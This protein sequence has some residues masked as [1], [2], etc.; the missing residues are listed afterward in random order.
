MADARENAD[1]I[2]EGICPSCGSI[3]ETVYDGSSGSEM[4]CPARGCRV[5]LKIDVYGDFTWASGTPE[6]WTGEDA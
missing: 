4:W 1:Y 6:N 3:L 5:S 2:E